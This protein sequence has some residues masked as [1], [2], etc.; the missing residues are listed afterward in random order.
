MD[1][2]RACQAQGLCLS[3]RLE[4]SG[5]MRAHCSLDLPW[6]Q[7]MQARCGVVAQA[8]NPSTLEGQGG[9]LTRSGVQDQPGQHG[10][11]LS[12]L[13][14]QKFA[15]CG[16][17]WEAE[18]GGSPEVTSSRPDWPTWHNPIS[19]KNTK[20]LAGCGG[21]KVSG[22]VVEIRT[23]KS[24]MKF[25]EGEGPPAKGKT[26]SWALSRDCKFTNCAHQTNFHPS[27]TCLISHRYLPRECEKLVQQDAWER[28]QRLPAHRPLCVFN[29]LVPR[30]VRWLTPVIQALWEAEAGGSPE[31][32]LAV[33]SR[34]ECSGTI[35]AHYNL[36]FL[37]SGNSPASASRVA[38]TTGARHHAWLIFVFLVDMGFTMLMVSPR[39]KS[40][41]AITAHCSLDFPGSINP[42][43]SVSSIART[44]GTHHHDQLIFFFIF[45][46]DRHFGKPR[47]MD[48]LRSGV[49]DQPDQHECLSTNKETSVIGSGAW[50]S[51][52]SSKMDFHLC[53]PYETWA[54]HGSHG[55]SK[56]LQRD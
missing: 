44:A 52:E 32:S 26:H 14:I 27:H 47:Q 5:S 37:G 16:V 30:Q 36:C 1:A 48:H 41:G 54:I 34:L 53:P 24:G 25:L 11:T 13:K 38:G 23:V 49:R 2:V 17:L 51:T 10:E 18:A 35:S 8:C 29:V 56:A 20:K 4:C 19:T 33:W 45:C 50:C 55:P 6:A 40:S 9:R 7:K 39:L 43:T 28:L 22:D 15:G 46:R 12:L 21:S 31:M 42:L 3:P